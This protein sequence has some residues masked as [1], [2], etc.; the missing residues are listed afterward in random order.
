LKPEVH[1][2]ETDC[3]ISVTVC[4]GEASPLDMQV[5][6]TPDAMVIQSD[7][8]AKAAKKIFRTVEFPR[9]I[10]VSKVEARYANGCLVLTA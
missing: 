9:R 4:I 6:V 8:S 3:R 7:A 1:V 5:V 10:D 2:K